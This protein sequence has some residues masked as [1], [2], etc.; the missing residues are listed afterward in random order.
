MEHIAIWAEHTTRAGE[1]A[2]KAE[3]PE[4]EGSPDYDWHSGE[5]DELI[6]DARAELDRRDPRPGGAGMAYRHKA[7][8]SILEELG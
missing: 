1:V 2:R 6:A 8:R 5:R 7:A 4:D 3:W